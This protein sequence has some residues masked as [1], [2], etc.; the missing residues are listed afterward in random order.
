MNYFIY[1][2]LWC[3]C[4]LRNKKKVKGNNRNK[5]RNKEVINKRVTGKNFKK[6]REI[7]EDTRRNRKKSNEKENYRIEKIPCKRYLTKKN[8]TFCSSNRICKFF[9]LL[10]FTNFIN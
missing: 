10:Q 5:E 7:Q 4:V 6:K 8:R 2:Y 3:D 1:L 9:Q